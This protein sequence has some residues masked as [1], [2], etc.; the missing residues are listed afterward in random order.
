M[1]LI[2]CLL[3]Y[4]VF[5]RALVV[6]SRKCSYPRLFDAPL[7]VIRI[8]QT[9]LILENYKN[10]NIARRCFRDNTLSRFDRTRT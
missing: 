1:I 7:D 10:Y 4:C 6:E 9:S 3:I 5:C 2:L 8:S